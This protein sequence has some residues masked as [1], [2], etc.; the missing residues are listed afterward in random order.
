MLFT[1]TVA[2]EMLD[3][4]NAVSQPSHGK[5]TSHFGILYPFNQGPSQKFSFT[6]LLDEVITS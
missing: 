4:Q 6:I 3:P 5:L 1:F 2:K